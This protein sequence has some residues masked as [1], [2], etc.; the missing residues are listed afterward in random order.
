MAYSEVTL[1]RSPDAFIGVGARIRIRQ[2]KVIDIAVAAIFEAASWYFGVKAFRHEQRGRG[3]VETIRA[4]KD[5]TTFAVV[6]E[7]SAALAGLAVAFLGIFLSVW[8]DAPW[9]DGAASL[10]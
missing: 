2:V 10:L 5:P 8:L 7:D 9:L 6:L 3:V 4:T 1:Q